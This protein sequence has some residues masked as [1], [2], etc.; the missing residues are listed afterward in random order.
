MIESVPRQTLQPLSR[1]ATTTDGGPCK[2]YL[3]VM[4]RDQPAAGQSFRSPLIT[5]GWLFAV[6]LPPLGLVIG[7]RALRKPLPHPLWAQAVA[8]VAVGL[9]GT[10]MWGLILLGAPASHGFFTS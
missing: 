3:R 4:S 8:I 6:L 2:E 10:L 9:F 5:A 7:I 1:P